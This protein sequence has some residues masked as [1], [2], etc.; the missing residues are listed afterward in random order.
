MLQEV[1]PASVFALL[2]VFVR[3]GAAVMQFPGIGDAYVSSRI[4]L[5]FALLLSLA[6]TPVLSERLPGQPASV[7]MLFVLLIG[8]L[9]VGIFLGA[10]ARIMMTALLVAGTAI[11]QMTQMANALVNSA[12]SQQQASIIGNFLS[13]TAMLLIFALDLHHLLL[14]TVVESYAV[15][16]PGELPPVGDFSRLVTE[17]VAQSFTLGIQ[18]AAPFLTAGMI[19]YLLMGLLGRLMPQVQIFFVAMPLQIGL[20]HV[21]LVITLPALMMW[22]LG[23][24]EKTF[25]PFLG[26]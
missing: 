7:T 10:L 3:T 26:G 23:A 9:F 17:T 13:I 24:F 8:E 22:F 11:S 5:L 14:R 19:S 1:L 2:L 16:P 18:L 15:F 4:R 21:L 12:L 20:G 25:T 6:V